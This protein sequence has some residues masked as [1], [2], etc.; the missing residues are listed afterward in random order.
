MS[1]LEPIALILAGLLLGLFVMLY[2]M[3]MIFAVEQNIADE[4][5]VK[6]RWM[7]LM[8]RHVPLLFGAVFLQGILTVGFVLCARNAA[9]DGVSLLAYLCAM[10]FGAGFLNTLVMGTITELKRVSLL[11]AAERRARAGDS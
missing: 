8:N 9:S 11:R 5:R 1:N 3:R 6:I 10:M 4:K 2:L 7:L